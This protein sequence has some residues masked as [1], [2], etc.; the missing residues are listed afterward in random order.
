MADSPKI[1]IRKIPVG[2]DIDEVTQV[3][4]DAIDKLDS[5][6][7]SPGRGEQVG[8]D[9]TD[10]RQD[11]N[12]NDQNLHD[13]KSVK[14]TEHN[15]SAEVAGLPNS[16]LYEKNGNPTY[17]NRTGQELNL[18]INDPNNPNA[19]VFSVHTDSTLDGEGTSNDPLSVANPFTQDEK[20][21]LAAYP[22]DPSEITGGGGTSVVVI[23]ATAQDITARSIV[24]V[25]RDVY[26]AV[27]DVNGVTT[28]TDFDNDNWIDLTDTGG[29]IPP[30][31]LENLLVLEDGQLLTFENGD[32]IS[33]Q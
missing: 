33:L 25:N 9:G 31:Q 24:R 2:A 12:L 4:N 29:A 13:V 5:H 32:F 10:F 19:N 22:E 1:K 21:K 30:D 7:H 20:D 16:S 17:K 28:S 6:N 26:L 14:L 27:I 18:A 3:V 23:T 8:S 15:S 11:V